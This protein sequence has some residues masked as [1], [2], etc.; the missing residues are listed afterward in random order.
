MSKTK[1][2][3]RQRIDSLILAERQQ[4][5]R[6]QL[7]IDAGYVRFG[8]ILAHFF[9]T[10]GSISRMI[11]VLFCGRVSRKQMI[12]FRVRERQVLDSIAQSRAA[13]VRAAED[14]H[15]SHA[16]ASMIA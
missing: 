8:H 1:D 3:L 7:A 12:E 9:S 10:Q 5:R 4:Y 6:A 13:I 15:A 11:D 16:S 2:N 14:W